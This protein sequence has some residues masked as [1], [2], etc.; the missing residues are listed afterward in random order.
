[1][2]NKPKIS[3]LALVMINIIA[4][5]SLRG[6][7]MSASYGFSSLF[8]YIV[9][10]LMF[11]IPSSLVAAELTTGWPQDGGVYLWVREAFGK[12]LAFAVIFIQWVYNVCW[13]P[14]ILSLMA[15][16][17][18][19]VIDPKLASNT[20]YMLSV[21]TIT[22]WVITIITLRGMHFSSALSTVTAIVGTLIP[23]VF[24]S[25]LGGVW[26]LQGKPIHME[27]SAKAFLPDF[28]LGNMVLLTGVLFGLVGME[29]S[30]VHVREV[31]DPQRNY[32]RA[33][34]YSTII[35]LL[36]LVL[37]SLAVAT[38]VPPEKLNLVTALLD[39]F[40]LFFE[41]FHLEWVMPIVAIL[42]GVGVIGGVG[43]WIIGPTRGLL[44]SAHDGCVP[45]FLQKVNAKQMPY[46]ILITQ[47]IVF[48]IICSVFL[49]MPTINS[50]FWILSNLTS[51][52][53][54]SSYIFI[55]AAAIRL[56]YKYPE[57]KRAYKIPFGNFGI[58]VVGS[59]GILAS[60]F[61]V[62]IGFVPPSQF[63]VGS[64]KFY[65]T[66]LIVGFIGFYLIPILIYLLRKRKDLVV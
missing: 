29:M 33:L 49:V 15:A 62:F 23:M 5:D 52:L 43:A 39:A 66:F 17:L 1:M 9:C 7:P 56:R 4:I 35:I 11:F 14:T 16:T 21:V 38:V 34:Y 61:I 28:K 58:W 20:W 41:A 25:V 47:G 19:Y 48:S 44:V 30:A 31:K 60:L 51:Q 32:P 36:S 63:A 8:Y 2:T 46:A 57:V 18:A 59:A 54:L 13:Y 64:L 50:S 53:A 40:S 27:I 45:K 24:I 42:I 6:I 26:L 3:V 12:P 37:S 10:A 65:E 22:Y 55:F